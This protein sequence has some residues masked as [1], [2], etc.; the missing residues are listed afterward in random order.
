MTNKYQIDIPMGE[1]DYVSSLQRLVEGLGGVVQW[2][3]MPQGAGR[4][5]GTIDG[6]TIVLYRGVSPF[7][8]WFTLSHLFGYIIQ[9]TRPTTEMYAAIELVRRPPGLMS[10][11]EMS[12]M[13]RHEYEAACLGVGLVEETAD[14][15]RDLKAAYDKMFFADYH[16]LINLL[17]TGEGGPEVFHRFW[18]K[19][20]QPEP[21]PP[22]TQFA[23]LK[24]TPPAPAPFVRVV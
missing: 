15:P 1:F 8:A 14:I 16:Y 22:I 23:D 13:Y 2:E 24:V 6:D 5:L 21:I 3:D 9:R 10:E 17:N 20:P 7:E 18:L 11:E 12:L 19:E 4:H